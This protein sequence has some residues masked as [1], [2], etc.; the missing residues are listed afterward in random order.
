M[1]GSAGEEA[2]C[3]LRSTRGERLLV[4]IID[5]SQTPDDVHAQIAKLAGLIR[6]IA[7]AT[8]IASAMAS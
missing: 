4:R 5:V 3:S 8:A 2:T 1:T 6:S 7:A